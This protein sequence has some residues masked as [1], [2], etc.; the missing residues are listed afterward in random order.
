MENGF[1]IKKVILPVVF[2][3]KYIFCEIKKY[4]PDII[5]GLGQRKNRKT[6]EIERKAKNIYRERGQTIK[7]KINPKGPTEYLLNLRPKKKPKGAKIDYRSGD[8]VCNFTRYIIMDFIKN[9]GLK[10]KFMFLHIPENYN[11]P[12]AIKI[13][14]K[15]ISEIYSL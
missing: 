2:E 11:I 15:I 10:T 3:K 13:L 12:K 6:L 8:F 4:K 1:K 14:K 7:K 9:K 5:I